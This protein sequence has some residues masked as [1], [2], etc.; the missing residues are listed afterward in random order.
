MRT[1]MSQWSGVF[2]DEKYSISWVQ[3]YIILII[4]DQ[5]DPLQSR[6]KIITFLKLLVNAEQS[7]VEKVECQ[8]SGVVGNI[9]II[10]QIE[11][12]QN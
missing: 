12:L 5:E 6:N 7:H 2:Y 11:I 3:E 10:N 1:C 9:P 8:V 4:F